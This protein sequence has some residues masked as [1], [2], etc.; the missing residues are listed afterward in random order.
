MKERERRKEKK[1]GE[2]NDRRGPIF[3]AFFYRGCGACR[4]AYLLP[5]SLPGRIKFTGERRGPADLPTGS[6]P[7]SA[8]NVLIPCAIVKLIDSLH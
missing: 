7:L 6:A 1:N 4:S 5:R 8:R 3:F 2:K